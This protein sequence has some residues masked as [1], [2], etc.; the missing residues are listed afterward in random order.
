MSGIL[1]DPEVFFHL[2]DLEEKEYRRSGK[3]GFLL[4][5]FVEEMRVEEGHILQFFVDTSTFDPST[6]SLGEGIL[7]SSSR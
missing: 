2:I 5:R 3:E 7:I 6:V 4:A 1:K